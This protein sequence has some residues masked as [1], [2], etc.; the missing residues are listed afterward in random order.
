[1]GQ[2]P[3]TPGAEILVHIPAGRLERAGFDHEPQGV[4]QGLAED[5]A[6]QR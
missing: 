6:G 5:A 1:M 3:C 2:V 4:A